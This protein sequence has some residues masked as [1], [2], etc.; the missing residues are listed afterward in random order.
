MDIRNFL[1]GGLEQVDFLKSIG[2][3]PT[4]RVI[5]TASTK[6][7]VSDNEGNSYLMFCSNNYLG[8]ATNPAAIEALIDGAKKFGVGSGGSRLMSGSTTPQQELEKS[9]S[10]FFYGLGS[11]LFTT[12]YM[13]NIGAINTMVNPKVMPGVTLNEVTEIFSDEYNHAS[14]ID[15]CKLTRVKVNVYRHLDVDDLESKLSISTAERKVIITEGIYSMDGDIAPLDKIVKL[16]EKYNAV[17]YLDDAHAIGVLGKSGRGT[18]EV[19][20][21]KIGRDVDC[22]MGTFTKAFGAIGGFVISDKNFSDL[23]T[24]CARTYIFSAPIPPSVTLAI[25]ENFNFSILHGDTLRRKLFKKLEY[26]YSKLDEN[27]FTVIGDRQHIV[28]VLLGEESYGKKF[29]SLLFDSGI[30]LP[31][32]QWPAAPKGKSRLRVTVSPDHSLLQIE[33]L[34]YSMIKVRNSIKIHA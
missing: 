29:S 23:L 25:Q 18:T 31:L 5:N 28:P 14:I 16:K 17:L 7:V 2:L 9:L 8:L 10:S 6:P 24:V 11:V 34:I 26:L 4:P 27:K 22:V 15:A 33:K 3:F 30:Y 1:K 13:A 32:V 19:F 20:D 12:G 21:L